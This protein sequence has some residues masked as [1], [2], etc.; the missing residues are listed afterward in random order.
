MVQQKLQSLAAELSTQW[1]HEQ[2]EREATEKARQIELDQKKAELQCA[3]EA[4]RARQL[5][6]AAEQSATEQDNTAQ[7]RAELIAGT[8][9]KALHVWGGKAVECTAC[10]LLSPPE[11]QFCLYCDA[12]TSKVNPVTLS[13]DIPSTIHK[14]MRCSAKPTMSMKAVPPQS[15]PPY[16]KMPHS[17]SQLRAGARPFRRC[18]THPNAFMMPKKFESQRKGARNEVDPERW[19]RPSYRFAQ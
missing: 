3:L 10:H 7:G 14:R 16:R 17:S 19:P 2:A 1:Q 4:H 6:I 9:L 5:Q 13:P 12:S 15:H 18:A 11:S 8:M